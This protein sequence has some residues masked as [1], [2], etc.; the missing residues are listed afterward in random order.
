MKE[1]KKDIKN[2]DFRPCYLLYGPEAYLKLAWADRLVE[3]MLDPVATAMNLDRFEGN[4][5]VDQ[6]LTA[7]VTFPFL[8]ERRVLLITDSGLFDTGRKADTE[9][10]AD[11]LENPASTAVLIF[12]E[13]R[14]NA[15]N[16]LFKAVKKMGTAV[17]FKTPSEAEL[18]RWLQKKAAAVNRS[19]S[20]ETGRILLEVV[21][22]DMTMLH[23]ELAKLCDY[24]GSGPVITEADIEAV[25]SKTMEA[26]IFELVDALGQKKADRAVELY[27]D[28][29]LLKKRPID[30]LG[31]IVRQFRLLY[32]VKY[33]TEKGE[34][35][36]A[37]AQRLGMER[38]AFLVRKLQ[39]QGRNFTLSVLEEA[40][41]DCLAAD[42]GFKSGQI[43]DVLAV[44][45]LLLR[46][47][48]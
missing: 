17:E 26:R 8:A 20:E 18:I 1:L 34:N 2:K 13:S 6:I 40:M 9:A 5:P 46:Y 36:A 24:P 41:E 19:L 35:Q 15:A 48:A 33:L 22:S 27:R 23:N 45:L 32:Q 25:C 10:M 16:R 39:A 37:I 28:M 3:A 12:I 44:E 38:Q 42:V 30:I 7:A 31:M 4:A 21:G 29:L 43:D 11:Y 47:G 14:T